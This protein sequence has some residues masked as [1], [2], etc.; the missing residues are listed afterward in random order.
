MPLFTFHGQVTS[1]TEAEPAEIVLHVLLKT[2]RRD[3]GAFAV[4]TVSYAERSQVQ[5]TQTVTFDCF[6]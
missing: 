6:S 5:G 4:R 1:G 2:K 3:D